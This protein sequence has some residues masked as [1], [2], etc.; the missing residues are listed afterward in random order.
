MEVAMAD[1]VTRRAFASLVAAACV[2]G[3]I[4]APERALLDRKAQEMK[5]SPA[6]VEDFVRNG[7]AGKLT[8]SIPPTP[9][10]KQAMLEDLIRISCADGRVEQPERGLLMRYGTMLGI[11]PQELGQRVRDGLNRSRNRPSPEPEVRA[12]RVDH[13]EPVKFMDES[14]RREEAASPRRADPPEAPV[15][16]S[17]AGGRN[18]L[19]VAPGPVALA[20]PSFRTFDGLSPVTLELVKS[21][22]RFDGVDE[23]VAYL[24]RSCGIVDRAEARRIVDKILAETPDCKPGSQKIKHAR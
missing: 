15:P 20:P 6:E 9:L 21:V 18:L 17:M 7:L 10:G 19:A 4:A 8:V 16:P 22:I 5:I 23:A 3:K 2:D 14:A 13:P 24:G 11:D 1:I 12:P